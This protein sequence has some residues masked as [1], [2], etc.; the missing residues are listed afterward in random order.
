M[1]TTR[2]ENNYLRLRHLWRNLLVG[3]TPDLLFDTWFRRYSKGLQAQH[4][5]AVAAYFRAH[6][7][8]PM[9]CFAAPVAAARRQPAAVPPCGTR[10]RGGQA[11]AVGDVVQTD[12]DAPQ[13]FVVDDPQCVRVVDGHAFLEVTCTGATDPRWLA[14][15]A[16]H[17]LRDAAV[18]SV[19]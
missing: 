16:H 8:A 5:G 12:G 13:M 4:S 10:D 17:H 14:L 6:F 19:L 15:D 18:V 2:E 1:T 3:A 9:P 11:L 7:L